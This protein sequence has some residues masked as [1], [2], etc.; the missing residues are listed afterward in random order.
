[1]EKNQYIVVEDTLMKIVECR[2]TNVV[3]PFCAKSSG[4]KLELVCLKNETDCLVQISIDG[5]LL[6]YCVPAGGKFHFVSC[7]GG[8]VQAF[9]MLHF[10]NQTVTIRTGRHYCELSEE[11]GRYWEERNAPICGGN[12]WL[13]CDGAIRIGGY[14]FT[15]TANQN[16]MVYVRDGTGIDADGLLIIP[17]DRYQYRTDRQLMMAVSWG[18]L[19]ITSERSVICRNKPMPEQEEPAVDISVCCYGYLVQTKCGDVFFSETGTDWRKIGKNAT[20]IASDD[21]LIAFSDIEGNVFVYQ[22]C[23]CSLERKAPMRF[24]GTHITQLAVSGEMIALWFQDCTFNVL[25]IHTGKSVL[26]SK[27]GGAKVPFSRFL[28]QPSTPKCEEPVKT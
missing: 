22:I 4:K 28:R 20:A 6:R 2:E 17:E 15:R 19:C 24:Q 1:M 10:F 9:P 5:T 23:Q 25:D 26:G 8:F 7:Q 27:L 12:L 14:R 18:E 21:D 16:P 13:D 11:N 3:I